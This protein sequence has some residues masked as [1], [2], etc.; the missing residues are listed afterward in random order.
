MFV[1]SPTTIFIVEHVILPD[2]ALS[3]WQSHAFDIAMAAFQD[4]ARERTEDEYKE[5]LK[6]TWF[7]FQK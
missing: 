6:N 2:G 5:L 1:D 4:N 7:E 3:N